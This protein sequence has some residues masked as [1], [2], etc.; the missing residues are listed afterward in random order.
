MV[1]AEMGRLTPVSDK[2]RLN[3]KKRHRRFAS[4]IPL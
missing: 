4:S 2:K 3:A 1:G